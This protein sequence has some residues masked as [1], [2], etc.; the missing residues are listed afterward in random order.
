MGV[1]KRRAF[2]ERA[3]VDYD[4]IRRQLIPKQGE[5]RQLAS[6]KTCYLLAQASHGRVTFR[7]ACGHFEAVASLN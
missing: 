5:P 3:G 2:A 1:P 4:Y 7:D 6:L